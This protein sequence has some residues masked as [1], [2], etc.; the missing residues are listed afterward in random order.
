MGGDL[1]HL[2]EKTLKLLTNR[3]VIA[4]N[5]A[6]RDNRHVAMRQGARAWTA[7][8]EGSD[9][10]YLALFNLENRPS[11]VEMMLPDIGVKGP[12][13]ASDLWASRTEK[14][15]GPRLKKR[16]PPHGSMLLRLSPV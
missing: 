2:D 1:R 5:Q 8:P 16:L 12:V 3:N 14:L 6:S 4:V 9:D 11:D 10:Y 7:R 15:S 13:K